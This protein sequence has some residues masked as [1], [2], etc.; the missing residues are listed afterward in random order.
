LA[1][2]AVR[3]PFRKTSA[4]AALM[5]VQRRLTEVPE[6]DAVS[7]TPPGGGGGGGGGGGSPVERRTAPV[8]PPRVTEVTWFPPASRYVPPS[9]TVTAEVVGLTTTVPPE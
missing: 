2:V 7:A 5:P 4:R 6:T 1:T 9:C 3:E 8:A